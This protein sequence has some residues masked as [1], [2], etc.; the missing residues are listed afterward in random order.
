MDTFE[1][2]KKKFIV[3][4]FETQNRHI[5]KWLSKFYQKVTTNRVNKKS[6]SLF[7]HQYNEILKW[8]DMQP[9][10]MPESEN[11]RVWIEAISDKIHFH[12]TCINKSIRDYDLFEK[13][14]TKDADLSIERTHINCLVALD[15]I[16]SLFNTGSIFR[17]CD[18][19]RL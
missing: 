5:I 13:V 10:V 15:G 1:F 19:A 14:Q 18:A 4:C 9:F 2:T 16:R 17:I 12:R 7:A 6:L 3:Q 8:T 11:I